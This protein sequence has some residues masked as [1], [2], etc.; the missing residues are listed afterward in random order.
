[1]SAET[2]PQVMGDAEYITTQSRIEL[3]CRLVLETD[4]DALE[5]FIRRAEQADAF[6][7][8][9]DPTAWIAAAPKLHMV[10]AHARGLAR[11]RQ[12]IVENMP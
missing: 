1:M 11:L 5:G 2:E 4:P 7:P 6:A 9:L 12:T 10:M 8:L 3:L